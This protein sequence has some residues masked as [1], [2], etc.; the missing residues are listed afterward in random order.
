MKGT[1][2]ACVW[3]CEQLKAEVFYHAGVDSKG[4]LVTQGTVAVASNEQMVITR[5]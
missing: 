5:I 2:C 4:L 3:K 1:G